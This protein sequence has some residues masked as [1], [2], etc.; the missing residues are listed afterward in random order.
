MNKYIKILHNIIMKNKLVILIL[1]LFFFIC[2]YRLYDLCIVNKDKYN[3]QYID[4]TKRI[5]TLSDSPRGRIL[6]VN[7]KVLV[8]NMGIN[9]LVYNKLDNVDNNDL[10]VAN[11]VA[12]IL[13]IDISD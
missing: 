3:K 8:D 6:D 12:A 11:M 5:V 2:T 10:E 4:T 9:T 1:L 7:G 13:D